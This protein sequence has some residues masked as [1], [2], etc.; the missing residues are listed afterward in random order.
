M[1]VACVLY[2]GVAATDIVGPADVFAAANQAANSRFYELRYLGAARSITASNGMRFAVEPFSSLA[3]RRVGMAFVP[4]ADETPLLAALADNR[5][6]AGIRGL[7]TRAN[8]I[9]GVCSGAYLLAQLGVLDGRRAATHW[10]AADRLAA[11]RPQVSVDG[12]ALFVEDRGVWT[13]AGVTAG[14]DM[15]LAI[16]ERDLGH[17]IAIAVARELV[18]FLVRPG[19]QSQFS[20]P[21]DLQARA[22]DTSLRA[23]A[24]WLE[25]RLANQVS[26]SDMALAMGVSE[27]TLH[28]RCQDVFAMTPLAVLTQL[29]L[30]R[31]RGLLEDAAIPLKTVAEQCGFCDV[32]ALG[33]AFRTAYGTT[34][35]AYRDRFA[36][37]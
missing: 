35:G 5:L 37:H 26:I 1:I 10:R 13:S 23:L 17:D 9:C 29:R 7:A 11:T 12:H 25:V 31:A 22:R 15:A 27:R 36:R 32:S 16:V 21:L 3:R 6:T 30:D 8:R 14:I 4:G 28:R 18:L 20:A 33:K 19:G 34:P 2:E 24:P